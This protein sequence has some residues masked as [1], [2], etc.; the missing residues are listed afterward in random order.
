MIYD[1]K[2]RGNK[3]EQIKK[4]KSLIIFSILLS[5]FGI[6]LLYGSPLRPGGTGMSGIDSSIFIYIGESMKNGKIPYK[7]IFD[8]KGILLYIIE[9]ISITIFNGKIGI[10]ILELIFMYINFLIIWKTVKLFS[11]NNMLAF[12]TIIISF[13]P[14]KIFYQEGNLVEEWAL[15]FIFMIL[16]MSL[17]Y[18]KEKRTENI[19]DWW[20]W[21]AIG[22]ATGAILWLRPNMIIVTIVFIGIIGIDLL[23][24]KQLKNIFKCVLYFISGILIISMPIF[25]YLICNNAFKHCINSYLLFNFSYVGDKGNVGTIIETTIKFWSTTI[26][27]SISFIICI[28][29]MLKN[30]KKSNEFF[31]LMINAIFIICTY[32]LISI[33][34][35][36]Y[37]H[38]EMICIPTY[39]YPIYYGLNYILKDKKQNALTFIILTFSIIITFCGEIHTGIKA[40][41]NLQRKSENLYGNLKKY[42]ETNTDKNDDI[43][44]IGNNVN[45]NLYI[46]RK[47]NARYVYQTPIADIDKNIAKEFLKYIKKTKPKVIINTLPE[48]SK[49]N[50]SYFRTNMFKYYD[51]IVKDKEYLEK[52]DL[53]KNI[54]IY[55]RIN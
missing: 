7:D 44:V 46:D 30:N 12:F 49:K 43:I 10:W 52:K 53:E 21:T 9:F 51:N 25:I 45:I 11:T 29:G 6:Y 23:I 42:I 2:E 18:L 33:S 24:K 5:I 14:F 16:Y 32:I 37:A 35:R 27:S 17:K 3:V 19:I 15:P 54:I 1:Y 8:H 39:I 55:E 48:S 31:I 41:Q 36:S 50:Y 4:N 26:L 22:F 20:M 13:I 38:Y 34:G 28:I 40:T 47:N